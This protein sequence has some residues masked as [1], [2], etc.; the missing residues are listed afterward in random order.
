MGMAQVARE[1]RIEDMEIGVQNGC[2]HVFGE[3]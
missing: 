3:E 2:G 1:L